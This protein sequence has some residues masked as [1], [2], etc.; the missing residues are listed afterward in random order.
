LQNVQSYIAPPVTAVFLL[1]IIWKRV[2]SDAAITTL[3]A[4]FVLLVLRLGSEIYY[5]PQIVSDEFVDTMLYS[6]ATINFSHMAIFMF[7]FSV[8]LCISTSLLTNAPD[9]KAILGLSFGT[10]TKEQKQADKHS[11]DTID[12]V[13]SVLL[14]FL[15]VGILCYFTG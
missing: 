3:L 2:N 4:G 14:V 8:I 11:Y 15:V 13:L 1:G 5:Q 6:F 7:I 12:V 10:L 9:Y